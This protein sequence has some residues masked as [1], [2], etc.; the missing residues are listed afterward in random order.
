MKLLQEFNNMN[1][2]PMFEIE[3]DGVYNVYY[4][5]ADDYG[6]SAGLCFNTGFCGINGLN[7]AWCESSSLDSHLEYLY[8]LCYEHA[9]HSEGE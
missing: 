7:I 8:E 2:M 6:I 4:I 1:K 9:L 5:Q 3:I